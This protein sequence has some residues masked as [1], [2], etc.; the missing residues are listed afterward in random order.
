MGSIPIQPYQVSHSFL[1]I[2]GISFPPLSKLRDPVRLRAL[3]RTCLLTTDREPVLDRLSRLAARLLGTKIAAVTLLDDTHQWVKANVGLSD[4]VITT[5][6]EESYCQHAVNRGEPFVV[7]DSRKNRYVAELPFTVSGLIG[8]YVGCPLILRDGHAVGALCVA[9]AEPR[10]WSSEQVE[11]LREL[12]VAAVAEIELRSALAESA[13]RTRE[14]EAARRELEESQQS[15]RDSEARFRRL[16]DAAFEGVGVNDGKTFT[17]VNRAM[18]ELFGYSI[19]EMI[20]MDPALCVPPE[21]RDEVRAT[22]RSG[23]PT[24][25]TT[26]LRKSGE[27]FALEV[28]VRVSHEHGRDIRISTA[29]D[30]SVQKKTEEALVER[31]DEMASLSKLDELTGLSNRRGF[32]EQGK[33]LLEEAE[34]GETLTPVVFF[35]DV[36][37]M[38][39]VN[40]ELGHEEGDRLLRD[41][42][43]LLRATFRSYDILA[44][45]GGDE[46]AVLA[47]CGEEGGAS[48]ATRLQQKIDRFNAREARHYRISVSVGS[49]VHRPGCAID[50]LLSEADE[51]MYDAKRS[52][53]KMRVVEPAKLS[54]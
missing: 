14:A 2:E 52:S 33:K 20:G 41:V 3:M 22:I 9:D 31:A 45:L 24:Y 44:R 51:R 1:R 8:S 4:S 47:A 40:D 26:G 16:A 13:T 19:D 11:I 5:P 37:G 34:K 36:N 28:R 32:L 17:E 53:G 49:S 46:F 6:V 27:R 50:E 39:P 43:D 25:Q 23:V 30:I 42:A 54:A 21:L 15:L 48:V 18:A 7:S 29:R 10:A 38:K 35:V 12:S